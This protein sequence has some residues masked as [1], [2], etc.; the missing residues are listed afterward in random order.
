MKRQVWEGP[1]SPSSLHSGLSLAPCAELATVSCCSTN[2]SF[3]P[4]LP[5][6]PNAFLTSP[7]EPAGCALTQAAKLLVE[8]SRGTPSH[9]QIQGSLK[10]AQCLA[11]PSS[12]SG[13]LSG[14][15]P[16]V[17]KS[18][19]LVTF[20]AH[21]LCLLRKGPIPRLTLSPKLTPAHLCSLTPD[22]SS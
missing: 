18:T 8:A 12:L 6:L 13:L 16:A 11:N 22:H 5:I 17:L 3:E 7:T 20:P 14:L 10:P 1:P 19:P 2:T 9:S 15:S 4:G 21:R